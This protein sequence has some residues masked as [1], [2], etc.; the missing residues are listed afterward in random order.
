[1]AAIEKRTTSDGTTSYRVKVRRA[2][3]PSNPP[4]SPA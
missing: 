4:P 3:I 1:M 2:G